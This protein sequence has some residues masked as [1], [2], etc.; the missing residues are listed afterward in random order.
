MVLSKTRDES[1][2]FQT[3][4]SRIDWGESIRDLKNSFTWPMKPGGD[5]NENSMASAAAAVAASYNTDASKCCFK[6]EK[7]EAFRK[8]NGGRGCAQNAVYFC[9]FVF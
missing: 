5:V 1:P 8:N 2:L 6:T 3:Q 4:S 9:T 7:E